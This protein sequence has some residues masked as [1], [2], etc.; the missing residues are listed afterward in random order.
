VLADETDPKTVRAKGLLGSLQQLIGSFAEVLHTRIEILS[1]E[2][3]GQG[4]R[5]RNLL[6]CEIVALYFLGLGLLMVTLLVIMAA[7]E[8]HR[9][10]ALA[11]F[12]GLYLSLGIGAA[13]LLRH[14]RRRQPRLFSA[15]LAEL[16]KDRDHL[17]S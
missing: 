12:A 3:E 11:G 4:R 8:T 6:L 2:L 9:I 5:V 16:A 14:M 1:A 7:W 13:L 17:A 10:A 15:T